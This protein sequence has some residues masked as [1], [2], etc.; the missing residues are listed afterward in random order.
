MIK[1]KKKKRKREREIR[2]IGSHRSHN[3][4]YK[5]IPKLLNSSCLPSFLSVRA[6]QKEKRTNR[7]LAVPKGIKIESEPSERLT[8]NF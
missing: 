5:D 7:T 6:R 4:F 1:N 8:G 3:Y 2:M